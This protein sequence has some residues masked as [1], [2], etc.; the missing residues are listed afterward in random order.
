MQFNNISILAAAI[1]TFASR[2]LACQFQATQNDDLYLTSTVNDNQKQ[3]CQIN[4]YGDN[5]GYSKFLKAHPSL[6]WS[7]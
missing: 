5:T 3:T 2:T 6:H 1:L 7:L 4:G